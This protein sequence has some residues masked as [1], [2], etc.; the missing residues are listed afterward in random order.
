MDP[1]KMHVS[2]ELHFFIKKNLLE[3]ILLQNTPSEKFGPPPRDEILYIPGLHC[4][5]WTLSPLLS[6]K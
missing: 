6:A 4:K 2:P 1:P 5:I 3:L